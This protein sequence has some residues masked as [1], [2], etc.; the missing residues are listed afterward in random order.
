[1]LMYLRLTAGC[2]NLWSVPMPRKMESPIDAALYF[3]AL[4]GCYK[5]MPESERLALHAWEEANL[6]GRTVDGHPVGT[7]D[8]PGW[9][10]Y[11]GAKPLPCPKLPASKLGYVYLFRNARNGLTKIGFSSSPHFR[12]KILRSEEPEGE[13]IV[14]FKGTMK[15]EKCLHARFRHL[16]FRGEWFRLSPAEIKGP[17]G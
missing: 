10:K 17:H 2:P 15:D 6:G 5:A 14:L 12:E 13:I 11:I 3:G 7:S 1:M 9:E 16:H 4:Y 8:W